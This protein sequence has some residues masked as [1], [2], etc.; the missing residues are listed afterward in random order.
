MYYES[1]PAAALRQD[2][3]KFSLIAAVAVV[4]AVAVGVTVVVAVRTPHRWQEDLDK[5]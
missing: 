3:G 2:V 5:N 1:A 4:V